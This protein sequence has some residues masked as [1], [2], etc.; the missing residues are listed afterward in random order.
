MNT[1]MPAL[2]AEALKTRR[3]QA[4]ILSV[5]IFAIFP[6]VS[7]LFIIILRDPE[8]AKA[9]G[10]ISVKA[11]LIAGAADWP[12]FFDMLRQIVAMAGSVLYAFIITWVFGREFS[13]R[14][15]KDL[16][17]L[18]TPRTFIVASKFVL[19]AF[20]TIGLSLMVFLVGLGVGALLEMPGWSPG[21]AWSSFETLMTIALL[22]FALM[23]FV[24]LVASAGG[25]YLPP[26]GWA[27]GSFILAQIVSVLGW[28]DWFPWS[29]P[30]LLSGMFGTQGA[31]QIGIHSY[32]LAALAFVIGIGA[33][34][35]WWLKADQVR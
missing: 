33:T 27:I 18:P 15:A 3:S 8:A 35:A 23:P 19:A 34:L 21:L 4:S 28:G 22:T 10:L 17:A 6:L 1:F 14:T 25:G 16:M 13:D 12:A 2:W 11:Q 30:V 7:G 9:M 26:L 32:I 5:I 20:W 24:A 29:V 31:E